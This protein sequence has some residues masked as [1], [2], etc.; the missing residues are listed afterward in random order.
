MRNLLLCSLT[1]LAMTNVAGPAMAAPSAGADALIP[2][3]LIFG[4]PT[5][6]S[7]RIS[8]DGRYVSWL[9][10]VNGVL[11]IWVAP[12]DRPAEAKP[13]TKETRRGLQVYGWAPD[14]KHVF[15][16][17]DDGGTENWRVHLVDVATGVD[18]DLLPAKQGA[19][20][21]I[22]GA[23]RL[24]PDVVLL[25]SNE[26]NPQ[27]FDYFEVNLATGAK[28][29]VFEN[30]G[31]GAVY[32]DN[33]LRPR[34]ASKNVAGGATTLYRI[35]AGGQATE[36]ATIA[37]EDFFGFS[38][39]AFDATG[40]SVFMIDSRGRDTNALVAMDLATG[41]VRT[42]AASDDADVD[43]VVFDP[44]TYQ[45]LAYAVDRLKSDW[46][47]LDPKTEADLA[48]LER[49]LPGEL[50]FASVTDDGQRMVVT[51][52]AAESPSVSYLYDR[53][54]RQ[55]SKLIETRPDLAG[56]RLAPMQAVEVASRDGKSLVTY[57]TLPPG[58]DTNGDGV[59]EKAI[60]TV[61]WVHG[62]PWAR[63]SYGFNSVHQWLANR[64]YAVI[65]TNFRGSTGF[66][67]AFVNAAVGEWSGKMHD[68]LIDVVDWAVK[69][70]ISDPKKV[71]IG[72]GSYGGYAT[73]VGVTF[74][75]DRF[76]CGVDIVGPSN[77]KTLMESFPPYWRPI[78]AGTF[79]KHIGD[80]ANPEDV[81]R[82]LAQSP[83]SR[84]DAIKV[85]LL[86]GQGANDPRVVKAESDQIV[87]AMKAKNLPV[88]YILYPDEGHGFVRPPNRLSFF[89][90][91]EGFLHQCLGGRTE[92]IGDA[93]EGST[94][95]VL[96]GAAGVSGLAEALASRPK[97]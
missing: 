96:D 26:R 73:L 2:R 14:S 88:T 56:Y 91:A 29:L 59:P 31:F 95:Q 9:A 28:T 93:L 70:G 8:P 27:F 25:Q 18:R 35:E 53:K 89:A 90:V 34:L 45:P 83:I 48:D 39:L 82:M 10:P 71:A 32:A 66:G 12:A 87:A 16:Q 64:G 51:A 80:P 37:A 36:I 58:S 49:K 44:T 61:L 55:L 75:P 38:P 85:P 21:D 74:T 50:G 24:R 54:T 33:Q 13:I 11:N 94:I 65:S 19:R 7:A 68:D 72:G 1:A 6:A 84:V 42:I 17:Q 40:S 78:L 52:N 3:K 92:P 20:V 76:A 86:I 69:R 47:A 30:P 57:V 43:S 67:K 41:R 62:G 23:S 79:F 63:D 22:V 4:N 97:P 60:P 81:K 5:R 77:L 46:V 15:Y